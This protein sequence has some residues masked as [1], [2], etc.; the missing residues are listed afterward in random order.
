MRRQHG[1]GA[2]AHGPLLAR[3]A[4]LTLLPVP[5]VDKQMQRRLRTVA[6][7]PPV[8][9][10]LVHLREHQHLRYEFR[11]CWHTHWTEAWQVLKG[12]TLSTN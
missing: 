8:A 10:A 2:A 7:P 12:M 9:A 4:S 5:R 11:R 6:R 3:T 1:V